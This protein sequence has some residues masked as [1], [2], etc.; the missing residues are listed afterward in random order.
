VISTESR[1]YT[2]PAIPAAIAIISVTVAVIPAHY[3]VIPANA[4]MDVAMRRPDGTLAWMQVVESSREQRPRAP[5]VGAFRRQ[6]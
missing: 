6:Q 3:F 1:R 2:D 4:Y 5:T